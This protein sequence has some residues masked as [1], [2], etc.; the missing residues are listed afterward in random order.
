MKSDHASLPILLV[1]DSSADA[2]LLI[3]KFDRAGV[4]N[5]IIH[6]QTGDQA[7]AYIAGINEYSDR[8]EYPLPVLIILDLKLPGMGGMELLPLFRRNR[9]TK[10]IPIIVLTSEE[11]ERLVRGAYELGANSYLMKSADEEKV[12]EIAVAIRDYWLRLNRSPSLVI[13]K[14]A[15]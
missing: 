3:R 12:H 1:E 7:L 6:L 13:A 8:A 14:A 15:E 9:E 5:R 2:K 10:P 4:K 11:D